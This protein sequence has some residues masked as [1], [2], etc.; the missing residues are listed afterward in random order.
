[1]AKPKLLDRLRD[2]VRACNYS[3]RTEEAYVLWSRR[4][5]LFH[6]KRHPATMGAEEV[7][8]FLGSLE[9]ADRVSTGTQSQALAAI[10]FLYRHVLNDP[11]PWLRLITRP[12][13]PASSI[14]V[15]L[16]RAQIDALLHHLTAPALTVVWLIYGS[17]LTLSE[18]LQLR[19]PDVDLTRG[20][21]LVR[22]A[23][24]TTTT[25]RRAIPTPIAPAALPLLKHQLQTAKLIYAH[26]QPVAHTHSQAP[27]AHNQPPYAHS[28]PA[29]PDPPPDQWLF[30]A[31]TPA[32]AVRP[33]NRP[34]HPTRPS[35]TAATSRSTPPPHTHIAPTTILRAIRLA[36]A[37]ANLNVR[38]TPTALRHAFT[39]P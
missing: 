33:S 17:G 10:T 16:T 34:A 15:V 27:Y 29:A 4:F 32:R 8:S 19:I 22:P 37:A 39:A 12:P 28:K 11:A 24:P 14:P 2:A 3:R 36:S 30:P 9:I 5:I 31:L 7:R 25:A 13:R 23:F 20:V 26:S 21:V 1:M 35:P 38:V 6:G 18:A